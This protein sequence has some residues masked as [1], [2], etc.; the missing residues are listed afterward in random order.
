MFKVLDY[1][2]GEGGEKRG[3]KSKSLQLAF[4]IR[5]LPVYDFRKKI[6]T[7]SNMGIFI[8]I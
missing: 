6:K 4:L 3:N 7:E 8:F 1:E 5:I 2:S